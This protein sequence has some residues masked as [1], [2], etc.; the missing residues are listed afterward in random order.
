MANKQINDTYKNKRVLVTGHTGFKGTWL[1]RLLKQLGAEVYGI[2]LEEGADRIF[3]ISSTGDDMASNIIDIRDK[4]KLISSI[5]K[6]Q[7]QVVFHLAAQPLV[8]ESYITPVETFD[9][10]VMGTVHVLEACRTIPS[11]EAIVLITTDKVYYN[12][13]WNYPYRESD[14]LGGYDPY[15]ASKAMCELAIDS[16][17]N[18]FYK[19]KNIGIASVRAGNV[20]GGGDFAE[21]RIIPDIVR[22]IRD[23]KILTLRNP[24]S[25]R[26]WQHVLDVLW[27]YLLVGQALIPNRSTPSPS[28]NVAPLDN[29]DSHTVQYIVDRFIN[30]IGEG[31]YEIANN[32]IQNHEMGKLRLDPS[33]ILAEI[34][35]TPLFNTNEA[36][37]QTAKEYGQYLKNPSGLKIQIDTAIEKYIQQRI[38]FS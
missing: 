16:Y 32:I 36:I 8:L 1:C 13:E 18:S 38:K 19:E 31:S 9:T 17:K 2:G 12:N 26:P 3:R 7:P 11:L 24:N 29:S 10:N 27:A 6:I 33:L 25:V 5:Q 20:I 28:Y 35:W 37:D 21:N 15:S 14:R 22:S 34:G 30:I 4:E 23:K